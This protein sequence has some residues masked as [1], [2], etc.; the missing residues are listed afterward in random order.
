MVLDTQTRELFCD[1]KAFARWEVCHHVRGLKWF[2]VRPRWTKG[3]K[4]TSLEAFRA[5]S[6]EQ[7]TGKRGA[8]VEI[9]RV[10][11]PQT[12]KQLSRLLGWPINCVVPRRHE[13]VEM[14]VIEENGIVE[15][16][17]TRMRVT[18]WRA[19]A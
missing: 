17:E 8:V 16:P 12:D 10:W 11:G 15:D 2:C 3:V 6:Q 18:Q 1:C 5:L 7:L 19:V 13:G 4:D 9:L 14:G